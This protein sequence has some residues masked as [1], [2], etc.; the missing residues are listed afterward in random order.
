[1]IAEVYEQR[2]R[3]GQYVLAD[4]MNLNSKG[5]QSRSPFFTLTT[6]EN[7][8]RGLPNAG[9]KPRNPHK[10]CRGLLAPKLA[11]ENEPAGWE[12]IPLPSLY[13]YLHLLDN[14][15]SGASVRL[16]PLSNTLTLS[17]ALK[18]RTIREFPTIYVFKEEPTGFPGMYTII[19]DSAEPASPS[20]VVELSNVGE[21]RKRELDDDHASIDT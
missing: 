10:S 6:V 13:F 12:P 19:R 16:L 18:G 2:I 5:S 3:Q 9:R 4:G 8:I 11:N 17:E 14:S 1:M 7:Y 20:S 21:K 15:I